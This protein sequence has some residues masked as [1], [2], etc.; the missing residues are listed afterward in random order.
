MNEELLLKFLEAHARIKNEVKK[1]KSEKG[2]SAI[3]QSRETKLSLNAKYALR[4]LYDSEE[5][6]QRNLAKKLDVS[7][8]AMSEMVKVMEQAGYVEKKKNR[9]NN[10]NMLFLTEAGSQRAVNFKEWIQVVNEKVF[11]DFTEEEKLLLER[12][13]EKIKKVS[14]LDELT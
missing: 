14:I 11:Q 9:I 8:Q 4:I 12:L 6:N 13:L 3:H 5:M 1:H 10:E 2:N 7:A